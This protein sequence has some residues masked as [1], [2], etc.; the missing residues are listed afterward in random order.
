MFGGRHY[1]EEGTHVR[2]TL[3]AVLLGLKAPIPG[4]GEV[5]IGRA[6]V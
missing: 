1:D 6:H 4:P 2:R 3:R 5:E